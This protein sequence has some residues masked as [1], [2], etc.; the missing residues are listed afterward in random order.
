MG[1]R[2]G[3]RELQTNPFPF[4]TITTAMQLEFIDADEQ[5]LFCTANKG[6][7]L[8][9]VRGGRIILACA[10]EAGAKIPPPP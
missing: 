8:K 3:G 4:C 6:V 2:G 10:R 5:R 7:E 9:L 1:G